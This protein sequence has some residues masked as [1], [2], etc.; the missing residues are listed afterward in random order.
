MKAELH[1]DLAAIF[2]QDAG[3]KGIKMAQYY[4]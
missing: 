4:N 2:R 1:Q 3:L